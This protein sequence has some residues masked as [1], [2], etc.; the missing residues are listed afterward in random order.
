[1]VAGQLD[2]ATEQFWQATAIW[3]EL[4]QTSLR[5]EADASLAEVALLNGEVAEAMGFVETAVSALL[6][7]QSL[8]GT[9]APFQIYLTCY[10]VLNAAQDARASDFLSQGHQK[11]QE[12][13][14]AIVDETSRKM[15]LENVAA[16]RQLAEAFEKL[17]SS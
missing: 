1:M 9:A 4:D 13:A 6:N 7:G 5:M 8:D 3:H 11:M 14:I 17:S 16:H 15:F 2:D 12:R 10:N